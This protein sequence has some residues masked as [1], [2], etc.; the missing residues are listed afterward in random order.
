[1][2]WHELGIEKIS[3]EIP[4]K[5][6]LSQNYP[7]PFNPK[8]TIR[9]DVPSVETI[10]ELSLRI[11]DILGR[12]IATIVNQELKPGSYNVDWDGTNYPGGVYL[13]KLQAGDYSSVKKMI[14][15]K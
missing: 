15:L 5:F 10:H 1:V 3:N 4:A 8:T 12:E 7:N 13:Y 2:L 14:L 6:E 9:F 11:Y